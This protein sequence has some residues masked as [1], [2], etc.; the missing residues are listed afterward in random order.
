ML[1]PVFSLT[2]DPKAD[3]VLTVPLVGE[4]GDTPGAALIKSN[5][6]NRRA[7]IVLTYSC[8][9]Q[10][11]NPL[12]RA[13]MREPPSTTTG[14]AKRVAL[15]GRSLEHGLEEAIELFPVIQVHR[16]FQR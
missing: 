13:S 4:V 5:M 14:S 16:R 7:G 6:L 12:L 2:P 10:V 15:L 8:P 11:S 9:K 1:R 3:T